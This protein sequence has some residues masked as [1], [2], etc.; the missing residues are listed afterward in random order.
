M[1]FL[2]MNLFLCQMHKSE[3]IRTN[4]HQNIADYLSL[5]MKKR[6]GKRKFKGETFHK[7]FFFI[8]YLKIY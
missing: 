1:D 7:N 8:M 4:N 3:N 6:E 5:R 2:F